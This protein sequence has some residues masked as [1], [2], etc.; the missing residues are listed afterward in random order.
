MVAA[1]PWS[2]RRARADKGPV[3]VTPLHSCIDSPYEAGK[4]CT[5]RLTAD[6]IRTCWLTRGEI[7]TCPHAL[8]GPSR[9]PII[10][11][12]WRLRSD[13][14]CSGSVHA[15]SQ[16]RSIALVRPASAS[17][18][19]SFPFHHSP[20]LASTP[21]PVPL[22]PYPCPCP[23]PAALILLSHLRPPPP[24]SLIVHTDTDTDTQDHTTRPIPLLHLQSLSPPFLPFSLDL[25]PP[26]P[27]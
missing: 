14:L 27:A 6:P 5:H 24:R 2:G 19:P 12:N 15:A 13:P 16:Q 11:T 10:R 3:C 1:T 23:C 26:R 8:K 22:R 25:F 9:R 18:D 21:V 20:S 17:P 4:H 7:R